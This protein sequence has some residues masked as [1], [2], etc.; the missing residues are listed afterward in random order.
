MLVPYVPNSPFGNSRSGPSKQTNKP[1]FG[2][3]TPSLNNTS[4]N[5]AP[6]HNEFDN[7]AAPQLNPIVFFR[8]F[9]S[10][11]LFP[12]QT[13]KTGFVTFG[14]AQISFMVNVFDF[15]GFSFVKDELELEDVELQS[16]TTIRCASQVKFG[17]A[18]WF[19]TKCKL[20]G[21]TSPLSSNVFKSG[22]QL[23]GCVPV[24][25]TRFGCRATQL[26]GVFTL[27]LIHI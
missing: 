3:L 10:F 16:S 4:R 7:P 8:M 17:T 26:S 2:S 15:F 25:L 24:N 11:R 1:S 14:K 9:C 6:V 20:A 23:N 13:S 18:P 27:S 5:G 19:L 22:S 12:A 21:V